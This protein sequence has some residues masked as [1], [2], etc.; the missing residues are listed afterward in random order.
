MPFV[1]GSLHETHGPLQAVSQQTFSAEHTPVVHSV[2]RLHEEPGAR[3]PQEPLMQT[4]LPEQSALATQVI[5]QAATPHLYEK[6]DVV[7]GVLHLPA[8]SQVD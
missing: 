6:Q 3:R 8:P 2:P 5:L 1:A 4:L 7:R